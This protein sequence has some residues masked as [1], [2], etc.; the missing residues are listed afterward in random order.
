MVPILSLWLP[1]LL[2]AVIVFVA[3]S[4]VHM[5]LTYHRGDY[6]KVP[7]EDEFMDAVRRLNVPPGDYMV[8]CA[9]GP[10]AMKD[11]AFLEKMKKG[12]VVVMTVLR[13]GMSMGPRLA[14]WFVYCLIVGVLAAY[15]TG[16]AL[17]PGAPYLAVFRF[18]GTTAFIAYTVAMW[19]ASIWYER[20]WST[21]FKYTV[22]GLLFGML[23]AGTFGWL[24]P[25]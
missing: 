19:Q 22:D 4:L 21:T 17:G 2:S 5:V 13:G 3:S 8:P 11:P 6:R 14:Q 1:I 16:R 9:G 25:R 10:E 24:W 15:V 12:P 20:A 23:T 7:A 18:A